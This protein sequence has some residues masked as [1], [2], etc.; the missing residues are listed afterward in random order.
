MG[1]LVLCG[2][3]VEVE[4]TMHLGVMQ[5]DVGV[6]GGKHLAYVTRTTQSADW[7]QEGRHL[8]LRSRGTRLSPE[9]AGQLLSHGAENEVSYGLRV[10]STL[11]IMVSSST[12]QGISIDE[13]D[14]QC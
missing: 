6:A 13:A 12:R 9:Y 14:R 5:T 11:I 8:D 3:T 4:N 10:A 7:S 1:H 2:G